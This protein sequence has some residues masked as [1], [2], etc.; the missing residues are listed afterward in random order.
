[1]K[2]IRVY[3]WLVLLIILSGCA[4]QKIEQYQKAK[5]A[6]DLRTYFTGQIDGW[7]MFQKDSGEVQKRFVVS[8]KAIQKNGEIT[9]DEQFVWDDGSRTQRIWQLV[10]QSDGSWKGRAGDVVGHAVGKVSGNALHWTYTLKL[11]VGDKTYDVHFDDWMYLIDENV[12][13]NRSVMS[14]WGVTLG[15]VTLSLHKREKVAP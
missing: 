3:Y 14:K 9:L 12:M 2:K 8:I 11:P 13:L 15:S 1:M 6:L 10:Q 5:P 4:G 7:G